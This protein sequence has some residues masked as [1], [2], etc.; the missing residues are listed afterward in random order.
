MSRL[1]TMYT[2]DCASI[3]FDSKGRIVTVCVGVDR[4]TLHLVDPRT[5]DE[6]ASMALPPR[7]LGGDPTKFFTDFTGGGY[8]FLDNRDRAVL[9]TYTG[10]LLV[11][12]QTGSG[13][14]TAFRVERDHD[15]SSLLSQGDRVISALPDWSGRLWFATTGGVVG[16]VDPASG[17]TKVLRTGEHNGNSFAVDETGGVFIV[18]DA[19]MYRFDAAADGTPKVTWREAYANTGVQKPGQSQKGSGTTPTLMGRDFVSITD[20]A[21]PM[22]VVVYRRGRNVSGSR[23]VCAVPVFT[24]GASDTDQSLIGTDRSMVVENNYGYTGPAAT[25][26]GRTTTPGLERVDIDR[27]DRSCHRVWHSDE[28]APSAVPKL[29]PGQRPR[30]Q[31]DQARA[32]RRRRGRVVPDRAGLPHRQDGL[33]GAGGRGARLQQPLRRNHHRA[34]RH[35]LHGDPRRDGGAAR[36]PDAP[37]RPLPDRV[38][39]HRT[40]GALMRASIIGPDRGAVVSADFFVGSRR[41]ARDTTAPFSRVI[42]NRRLRV[43]RLYKLRTVLNYTDGRTRTVRRTFR[44]FP[45]R[46]L[47][48]RSRRTAGR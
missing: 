2:A 1:S 10:H 11:V 39:L 22:N 16:T 25:E 32:A 45:V 36:R 8:F 7:P 15:L 17:A 13:D 21:D 3:T 33:Q 48:P 6:I 9:T 5:L 29:S 47:L 42:S 28:I 41:V 40:T 34:R 26:G 14:A 24:K 43:F 46:R 30:L 4:P 27:G 31:L 19:A 23:K 37:A 44:A 35:R 18:T 20:N 38:S 12:G